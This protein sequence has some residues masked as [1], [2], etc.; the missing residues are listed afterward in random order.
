MV[1]PIRVLLPE[2]VYDAQHLRM[3]VSCRRRWN[4]LCRCSAFGHV[5]DAVAARC[6]RTLAEVTGLGGD[7][8]ADRIVHSLSRH[9]ISFR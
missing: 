3:A 9:C 7:A 8:I 2:W 4:R 1:A 6:H 5:N